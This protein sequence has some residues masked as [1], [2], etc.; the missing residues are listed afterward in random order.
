[1]GDGHASARWV[2]SLSA[3]LESLTLEEVDVLARAAAIM[4]RVSPAI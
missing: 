4:E 1:M 3:A 2:E